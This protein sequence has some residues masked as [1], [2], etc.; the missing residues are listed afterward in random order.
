MACNVCGAYYPTIA[1]VRI[2][3][4]NADDLLAEHATWIVNKR[5]EINDKKEQAEAL[6]GEAPRPNKSIST[7]NRYYDGLLANLALIEEEMAPVT[8]YL[9]TRKRKRD[10]FSAFTFI[11]WPAN[12][13]LRYFYRDWFGTD[14]ARFLVQL[15]SETIRQNCIL[16][17][18]GAAVLGS[19][20][21]GMLHH[22][23]KL[24]PSVVG[25]DLAV[26]TQLL[27]RRML[28]GRETVFHFNFPTD[29]DP[30]VQRSVRFRAPEN[31]GDHITLITSNVNRLPLPSASLT[32]VITQYLLDIVPN[33]LGFATELHRVL[34]PGGIWI[35]FG[36]PIDHLDL[37]SFIERAGFELLEL[38][39]HRYRHLD[40]SGLSD[41][42]PVTIHNSI[43]F[44]ARKN[45]SRNDEP[46]DLF[47][48]Y[49]AKKS[50][51][52]WSKTPRLAA[53]VTV[54]QAPQSSGYDL[55]ER[56]LIAVEHVGNPLRFT[57]TSE[58][59]IL[60]EWFLGHINGKRS[61]GEITSLLR[62]KYEETVK[63][64]ELLQFFR[65]L[66]D[67]SIIEING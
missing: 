24:F 39:M 15:F 21:G 50:D 7:L 51:L 1:G 49:F 62:A 11:G 63:E 46:S 52:I 40:L 12:E 42:A 5:R 34:A 67:L 44:A 10:L 41:L 35:S 28:A 58:A 53:S 64:A 4:P 33:H 60:V 13:M 54:N 18:G 66:R 30:R 25:I 61:L 9:A 16:A 47:A 65:L 55:R 26:D 43:L 48:Q 31:E 8:H 32:C 27:V 29:E 17:K 19:G 14:E 36:I 3:T 45:L 2:L 37:P 6:S 56:K 22:L 59:A 57:M 20:A 38:S 23:A